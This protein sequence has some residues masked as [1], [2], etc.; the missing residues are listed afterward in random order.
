MGI[1][2]QE[3]T[4]EF[5]LY[6]GQISYLMKILRN[7]Q[8]GQLYFGKKI[9]PKED[10][11]YLLE[12]RYRPAS[13][14]VFDNDYSFS[15]EHLKQEYPAYGTT[16]FR[17]PALEILQPNGSR[18][19][20]FQYVSH[21]IY[22]GKP[23][24]KGLP[25]TYTESEEEADTLEL[26][27]RDEL[28]QIE[29]TL[30]YTIF[31]Q[32]NAIARSVRFENKGT[33]ACQITR[34]MSLSLDLP[35]A[36]YE[37][38]QFSGAWGRERYV[39][40][41]VLQ[42][43][44]QSVNSTRGGSGHF[45]NPF[46]MLK[47]PTADEFQGEVMGFSLV[48]SGNFLAQ[49]EVDTY[50]VTRMMIGINPFGFS[51]Q[52]EPEEEFQ[53]PEAVMVYSAEGMNGM[54]QTFHR[55]YRT[56]LARGYWRDRERPVLIN[57]WEATYFD[58]TEEKLLD[59]AR[60]AKEDG[61]ELFVLDDGWFGTRYGETSGLGDWT[62]NLKR[63]PD[64]IKGLSEKIEALGLKFGLW[65]ELEMVNKDSDLYR[66]H[67]DWIIQ[68]PGRHASH[69]R[70]QYVLDFSRKEVVDHIYEMVAA[71]LR[72]AKISYIKWDMNRYITEC[73]SQAYEANRQGEIFHRYILG[74][75]ELYD[76]LNREFPQILFESCASGGGRFDPGL[77][78][79]APQ[80]WTSDDSDGLERQKIQ[81]GTSYVYPISS[82]GAHVSITPNHQLNRI[83]PLKTRGYVAAFGAFGYEL[84]LARLTPEEREIVREQIRFVKKYR[85]LIHTGTFYRLLSP[86]EGNFTAWMVVSQDRR[87]A[88]VAY[89]KTLNDVN[90][91]YRRLRLK[92]LDQSLIYHMSE[93][94]KGQREFYGSE[95]MNIGIITTDA[96]AG[97]IPQGEEPCCD[98][99]SR[100]IILEAE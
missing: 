96:S 94:G 71:L 80:C 48:Y 25:A 58:F 57:N 78:Y 28:L 11:G 27:L 95:L 92:G 5:H 91:E 65:F 22:K 83:T 93:E 52:L 35:D 9:P 73:F 2:F 82:M 42:Q 51:W 38:I 67:P 72:E 20:D 97:E 41:R 36:D 31:R 21:K 81:Y 47:R 89:F 61:V 59:I 15:L 56:R 44:I 75:Y 33:A 62:P 90:R 34:A 16:D 68:T 98:F 50:D 4:G 64:G 88:I 60:T 7:G 100:M 43:G 55:L 66:S 18:I 1:I 79:Y 10:Y 45:H 14:Y 99:W 3:N 77:L 17:M 63:L 74:V 32:E 87:Q 70:K 84:D 6:N 24:L 19:T 12:N 29:M 53:T 30:V 85:K 76:R 8:L 40:T 54:S 23:A 86:F 39:K 49:A 69:G 46:V 26:L 37:W 13:A